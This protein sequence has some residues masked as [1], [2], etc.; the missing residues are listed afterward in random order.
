MCGAAFIRNRRDKFKKKITLLGDSPPNKAYYPEVCFDLIVVWCPGC[1]LV[2]SV[3]STDLGLLWINPEIEE[4][5][6][7]QATG[8]ETGKPILPA[9]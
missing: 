3:Q 6:H 8:N 9:T 1:G 4:Y 2:K 5:R 7:R